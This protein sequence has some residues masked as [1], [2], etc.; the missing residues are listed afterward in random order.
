MK[1]PDE[2]VKKKL[3]ESQNIWVATVRPDGRPHLAPVWF[4]FVDGKIY[5][6]TESTSVKAKNITTNNRVALTLEDGSHPV[7]CEGTARP[8]PLPAPSDVADEFFKKYE[9]ILST[10]K[11]Y[12]QL[13][14]VSPDKWVF[15]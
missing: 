13:F 6:S 12:S 4:V 15:W 7:I 2:Y 11:Q 3:K 8:L 5:L 9:W 10:E 1:E 14:E